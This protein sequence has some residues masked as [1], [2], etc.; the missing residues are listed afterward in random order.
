MPKH[1]LSDLEG[2]KPA[3]IKKQK[4]SQ[5][6]TT[7]KLITV[8]K[9][10]LSDHPERKL[11]FTKREKGSQESI[12]KR[13]SIVPKNN[14]S[15][16]DEVR[17]SSI[18]TRQASQE[19]SDELTRLLLNDS[20]VTR[21]TRKLSLED[22]LYNPWTTSGASTSLFREF[23]GGSLSI[24]IVRLEGCSALFVLSKNGVYATHFGETVAFDK[25]SKPEYYATT[26]LNSLGGKGNKKGLRGR[27]AHTLASDY[28]KV[29]AF[30]LTPQLKILGQPDKLPASGYLPGIWYQ[31][32][33]D[34]IMLT[35]GEMFPNMATPEIWSYQALNCENTKILPV[36]G[37]M[38]DDYLLRNH[39]NGRGLLQYK[40]GH[41]S[42]YFES[43]LVMSQSI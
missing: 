26:F 41:V 1:K 35:L 10:K 23:S 8:L 39:A 24:G 14:L 38:T 3:S 15:D 21:E 36:G 4:T 27:I 2:P 29:Y 11:S 19:S 22:L 9:R 18:K 16:V 32:A 5:N 17:P 13:F 6:S 30:M 12:T 25:V 20:F 28:A 37:T 33:A 31:E 43:S 7:K 40:D 34:D 42:L